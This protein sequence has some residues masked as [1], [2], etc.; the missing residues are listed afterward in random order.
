MF[1]MKMHAYHIQP[2]I[3]F[4]IV[5]VFLPLWVRELGKEEEDDDQD[6][7]L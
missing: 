7:F 4:V 1:D 3:F 5:V 2:D 6:F